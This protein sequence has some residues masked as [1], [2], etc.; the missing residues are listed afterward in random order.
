M[1]LFKFATQIQSEQPVASIIISVA[2]MMLAG[3]LLT[4][5]T[6]LLRLPNVTAYIVAGILIGPYCL[7]LVPQRFI[8]GTSCLSD[9]ALAFIA[10]STGEF[11][12]LDVLKKNGMKVV[13]ITVFESVLASLLV[14]VLTFFILHMDLAFSIVLSA[15]ASATAPAS[16]MMTIR[17]TGA[18]GDFVDTLL[19][20]VALD[21]VVGLVLYS[22]A[23]SVALASLSGSQGFSFQTIGK[24]ILL[25]MLTLFI[26]ACFGLAMKLLMPQSRSTDNKLIIS[27]ALL[28]AFCGVCVLLDVSPLLGCMVMGTVY[29]NIAEN[30]KL[31][32]QLGYF[33]PPIL[34]LFFVRSGMNFKLDALFNA[35]GDLD[36][37]PL[38]VVGVSYFLVRIVGKY[39]GAW[40][41]CF[42]VKNDKLVRNYL[43]L[44]LIPQAG[45]AIGLAALGART[46]GGTMGSDLE[47]IILASS[48]LY[49]L[50]GPGCAKLALYLSKSYS[51]KL[52]DVAVVE[53]V[54]ESG[55]RKTEAQLLI[56]RIRKIQTE[57]P[58][59]PTH[60]ETTE[61]EEAAFMEA[62]DEQCACNM[63]MLR[64]H[65]YL[66]R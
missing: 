45:V 23:I 11:F 16:T 2:L 20:V 65:S 57:L 29:T 50:L 66:R 54:T 36:G 44:A 19:Q 56:E 59:L 40:L 41:G 51:T 52:E 37:V 4:R 24:P 47:T 30:D 39:A 13:W 61:E 9:I 12:K 1:Q 64:R 58:P 46:L 18:K 26:G 62:A 33:S 34:L 32:K 49:E 21:D 10:F 7:N 55:E 15:L 17:Q 42:V 5:V 22:V 27:V 25:N 53:E 3:F 31:F 48:V 43:G 63:Q 35:S 60:G 6:K 28:F 14:F 8:D 38:I